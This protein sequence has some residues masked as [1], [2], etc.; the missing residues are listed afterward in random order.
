MTFN[1]N[2]SFDTG[3]RR[4]AQ[5]LSILA[6]VIC[7]GAFYLITILSERDINQ[8]IKEADTINENN[9]RFVAESTRQ[10]MQR[11]DLVLTLVKTD[12]ETLGYI[13]AEHREMIRPLLDSPTIDSV[14]VA[15]SEGK[16]IAFIRPLTQLINVEDREY[17]QAQALA[18][19]GL[20]I[21]GT[22]VSRE[23]GNPGIFLTRRINDRQGNFAGIAVVGIKKDHLASV[24]DKLNIGETGFVTLV[25]LDGTPFSRFPNN[26]RLEENPNFYKENHP[27]FDFIS[28]GILAGTYRI[29][30]EDSLV[31]DARFVAFEVVSGY[32]LV[33]VT[34][35]SQQE[36]LQNPLQRQR[37]IRLI[38]FS[39]TLLAIAAFFVIMKL[40][41][42]QHIIT[43]NIE[44]NSN[45]DALT[46]FLNRRFL[47]NRIDEE[48]ER[49][50]RNQ[51]TLSMIIFDIDKFKQVNDTFGHPVG[52][53]V[54]TQLAQMAKSIIRKSDLCIRIGGE[55]FLI[56]LPKTNGCS[57]MIVAEKIRAAMAQYSNPQAGIVTVSLGVA[58]RKSNES[59]HDWY[60]RADNALYQAKQQGRNCAVSADDNGKN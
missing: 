47:N 9:A 31:G 45:H 40:M 51:E 25:G 5:L 4:I 60:K 7:A 59:F 33:V 11:V 49:A 29:M 41:R 19:Q 17:F 58:E 24:F 23:T 52:D 8:T 22:Y 48:I 46:G 18:D 36:V 6:L 26:D 2:Y 37:Q 30:A 43:K 57:A 55:E 38:V 27:L 14:S 1:N 20:Y 28:K 13:T 35:I 32:P 50:E 56:V 21:G 16:Y 44:H 53:Q 39:F 12:M 10:M 15:D 3:F 42:K 34:G 54:L